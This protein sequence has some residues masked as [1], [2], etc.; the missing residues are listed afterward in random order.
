MFETQPADT[1]NRFRIFEFSDGDW[2]DCRQQQICIPP[3]MLRSEAIAHCTTP[4]FLSVLPPSPTRSG[5]KPSG[6][7]AKSTLPYSRSPNALQVSVSPQ[8]ARTIPIFSDTRKLS[9]PNPHTPTTQKLVVRTI[10]P[11][12]HT[13]LSLPNQNAISYTISPVASRKR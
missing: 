4:H 5:K 10:W 8:P 3:F 1:I 6:F 11:I 7:C 13:Q 12:T 2:Q 9:C